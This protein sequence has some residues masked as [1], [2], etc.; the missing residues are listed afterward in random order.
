MKT[1]LIK[2]SHGFSLIELLIAMSIIGLLVAVFFPVIANSY[3]GIRS[4]GQKNKV[5]YQV[6]QDVENNL[7]T[8]N[9]TEQADQQIIS[10]PSVGISN[11][12][13]KG[14]LVT[15]NSTSPSY[16]FSITVFKPFGSTQ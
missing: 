16:P 15:I 10:F 11:L 12:T 3:Y 14:K 5:I 4:A 7:L 13:V 1:Y 8:S 6:Q 9:T 2:S